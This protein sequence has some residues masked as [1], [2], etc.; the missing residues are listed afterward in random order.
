MSELHIHF[1]PMQGF[2]ENRCFDAQDKLNELVKEAKSIMC[3]QPFMVIGSTRPKMGHGG[4]I[5]LPPPQPIPG[6]IVVGEYEDPIA[7]DKETDDTSHPTG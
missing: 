5:V 6:L 3:I 1:I 7:P 2:R 4:N